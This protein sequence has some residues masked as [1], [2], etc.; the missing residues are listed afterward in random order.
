[1][2]AD[3]DHAVATGVICAARPNAGRLATALLAAVEGGMMLAQ[4]RRH[5]AA[6]AMAL[7]PTRAG[8]SVRRQHC[9]A[10]SRQYE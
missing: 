10:G 2:P 7:A 3:G 1:M 4:V 5:P 9:P 6:L 8:P